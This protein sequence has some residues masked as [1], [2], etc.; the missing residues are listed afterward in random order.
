VVTSLVLPLHL[1]LSMVHGLFIGVFVED[2]SIMALSGFGFSVL[3][4]SPVNSGECSLRVCSSC[5]NPPQGKHG[6][7]HSMVNSVHFFGLI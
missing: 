1:F 2:S 6:P 4:A 7:G 5:S 3:K